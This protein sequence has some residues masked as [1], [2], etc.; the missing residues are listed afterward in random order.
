MAAEK[1]RSD[2]GGNVRIMAVTSL[3]R[4]TGYMAPAINYVQNPEKTTSPEEIP[5]PEG[6]SRD[7]LTDLI[8]Y[9]ERDNATNQRQLITGIHLDSQIRV[10]VYRS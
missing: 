6:T 1:R 5:V 10:Y 8:A 3:W 7:T 4:I 9:T 2:D